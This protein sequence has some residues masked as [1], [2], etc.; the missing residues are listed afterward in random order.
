MIRTQVYLNEYDKKAI[1][2]FCLTTGKSQSE[3][4]RTAISSY[5]KDQKSNFVNS[6]A[7]GIWEDNEYDFASLRK[8][9]DRDR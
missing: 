6:P 8:G 9:F 7:F 4:I 3:I 2:E 5:I 1:E